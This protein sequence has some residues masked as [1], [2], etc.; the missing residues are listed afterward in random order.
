MYIFNERGFFSHDN[1]CFNLCFA[2]AVPIYT[3]RIAFL[4]VNIM[5]LYELLGSLMYGNR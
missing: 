4:Y 5:I 1:S 3:G 2:L